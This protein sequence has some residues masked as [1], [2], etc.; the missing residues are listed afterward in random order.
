[1]FALPLS[2]TCACI[3][4]LAV[5]LLSGPQRPQLL[6]LLPAACICCWRRVGRQALACLP[7]LQPGVRQLA[8]RQG[9]LLGQGRILLRKAQHRVTRSQV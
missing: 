9:Q 3:P 2:P 1:M 4:S 6:R 5:S 7:Q 8:L